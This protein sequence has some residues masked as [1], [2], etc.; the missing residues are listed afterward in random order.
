VAFD[1]IAVVVHP[2]ATW[3]D[4]LTVEEL[5]RLW[6]P[7]AEGKVLRWSAVRKGWPDKPIHLHGPGHASGT[8][9]YFTKATVGTEGSSRKDY[10]ASEDDEAI[11]SGVAGDPLA[12]GY[13]SYAYYLNH[14][15]VLRL[16]PVDDGDATNGEGPVA[17]SPDSISNATYQPL[18]RPLFL[19]VSVAAARRPEVEQLVAFYLQHARKVA[20]EV[21]DV[22]LPQRALELIAER[23]RARRTGSVFE[24]GGAELGITLAD[25]LDAQVRPVMAN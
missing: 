20:A 25:L 1:G 9:D 22:P 21:G 2:Q 15:D 8:F 5:K 23:F 3:V 17:P 10:A 7:E 18:S 6:A 13:F 24:G 19:Y 12:L 14:R 11:S 4:A 16:V